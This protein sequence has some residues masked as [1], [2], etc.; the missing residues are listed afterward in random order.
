M[1]EAKQRPKTAEEIDVRTAEIIS[2]VDQHIEELS[3]LQESRIQEA[4]ERAA[5]NLDRLAGV[6]EEQRDIEQRLAEAEEFTKRAALLEAQAR[7][8]DRD[9]EAARIKTRYQE[10]KATLEELPERFDQLE[11]LRR[12]ISGPNS[13]R[14]IDRLQGDCARAH[15]YEQLVLPAVREAR[16]R[17]TLLEREVCRPITRAGDR[18]IGRLKDLSTVPSDARAY[19]NHDPEQQAYRKGLRKQEPSGQPG[20][21]S[22]WQHAA[23][24]NIVDRSRG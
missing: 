20:G 4:I 5:Q 7:L 24:T 11:T 10:S 3:E 16:D 6:L 19:I 13:A 14:V 21:E 23:I 18:C 17:W 1:T 8:D 15:Q 9:D 22:G 2:I 12:E